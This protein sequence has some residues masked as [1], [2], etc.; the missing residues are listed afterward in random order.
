MQELLLVLENRQELMEKIL[1]V[2]LESISLKK[3]SNLF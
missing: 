1:G 3:L 2:F